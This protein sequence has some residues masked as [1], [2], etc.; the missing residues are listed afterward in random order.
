M[1]PEEGNNLILTSIVYL[2]LILDIRAHGVAASG[3]GAQAVQFSKG[4]QSFV[5]SSS[6]HVHRVVSDPYLVGNSCTMYFV[7]LP[8][9][10]KE[11][12][13]SRLAPVFLACA[14]VTRYELSP[15]VPRRTVE[16]GEGGFRATRGGVTVASDR[17]GLS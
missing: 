8:L 13:A 2:R 17:A 4:R 9:R 7:T 12:R 1:E 14:K 5:S 15:H 10:R 11:V 6:R 3:V 16:H